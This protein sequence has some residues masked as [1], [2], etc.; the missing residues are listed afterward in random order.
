MSHTPIAYTVP[1]TEVEGPVTPDASPHLHR[2]EHNFY[3]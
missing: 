1:L 3:G 2:W